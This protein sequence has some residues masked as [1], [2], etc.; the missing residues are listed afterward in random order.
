MNVDKM[1]G[2]VFSNTQTD[3]IV[4]N[5][6]TTN[7]KT[8]GGQ[9][10]A[11]DSANPTT[12]P[13]AITKPALGGVAKALPGEGARQ[14]TNDTQKTISDIVKLIFDSIMKDGKIDKGEANMV[15]QL[16]QLLKD[17]ESPEDA[18][19]MGGAKNKGRESEPNALSAG[20][21]GGSQAPPVDTAQTA[22]TAESEEA[23]EKAALGITEEDAEEGATNESDAA[24]GGQ[25][26]LALQGGQGQGQSQGREVG[27]QEGGAKGGTPAANEAYNAMKDVAMRDGNVSANEKAALKDFASNN[28][29]KDPAM[30]PRGGPDK[31]NLDLALLSTLKSSLKDGAISKDEFKLISKM[32]DQGAGKNFSES[33]KTALL[34]KFFDVANKDNN[35]SNRDLATFK[36][37]A[38]TPSRESPESSVG[39]GSSSQGV[40]RGG[41]DPRRV[42]SAEQPG[43]SVGPPPRPTNPGS[44]QFAND[45]LGQ[46]IFPDRNKSKV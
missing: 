39:R 22:D 33:Q 1:S 8:G 5:N 44:V 41:A 31:G 14:T 2:P 16:M 35:F 45:Q 38:Q 32:V 30:S 26:P 7:N 23:N 21:T 43:F 36:L 15:S 24:A 46:Y 25:Q 10:F 9:T 40:E 20:G 12:T 13:G 27:R 37:L 18:V 29:I 28:N 34:S 17:V 19:A 3:K 42:R 6:Q 4:G 11:T